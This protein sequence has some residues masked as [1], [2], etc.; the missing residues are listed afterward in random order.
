[1]FGCCCFN[2]SFFDTFIEILFIT[3]ISFF[4]SKSL[5]WHASHS[6]ELSPEEVLKFCSNCVLGGE[7]EECEIPESFY[8]VI[9]EIGYEK[10]S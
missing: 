10:S 3:H 9:D 6:F 2:K 1:M 8:K 7:E 4:F 5:A